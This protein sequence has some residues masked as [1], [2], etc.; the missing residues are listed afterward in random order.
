MGNDDVKILI[1]DDE[2]RN[3]DALEVMLHSTGCTLIRAHSADEALLAMLRH[4][5]AAM[6]LDIKMPGMSGIELANLV[7]QRRRTQDVPILF[8]TAHLMEDEDVLRGYG[9][10][11]VDYLS[12][13]I[14]ADI[15]RSKVAVFVDLYRKTRALA[16]LNEQLQAE[17]SERQRV[18]EAIQQIN[19]EL[20]LRVAERTAALSVAHRGVKENEERLRMA[21]DVAEIAAWEWDVKS[22]K[23][24]WSTDPEALFGFP[25]GCFGENLRIFTTLHADDKE[26]VEAAIDRAM[27]TGSTYECEYRAVRPD[28]VIVWIT[29][30]GRVLHGE[31]GVVE[32][33]VGVSRDVSAQRRAEHERE[34]LLISERAARDEAER[35]SRLKDEFLATLSHELR[36]PMNA[37]LGW[38][39]MLAKGEGVRN[40]EQAM[41]AIQRNASVQAKLIEDLLEMNKL[42]SGTVRLEL[43]L[44]DLGTAVHGALQ[45]LKP[46]ADTKG[47]ALTVTVDPAVPL[48]HA[49]E[50]RVQQI[51]WNLLHN[52]VKFTPGS[53]RV[54][55]SVT[56]NGT[57]AEVRVRDTGQGIP[58]EFLPF[59]FDRF[60]QADPSTTR[61]VWGLGIGLSIAKHLTELHGGSIEAASE[62]LDR[63]A[64]FVVHLP[65]STPAAEMHHDGAQAGVAL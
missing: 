50:R 31:D 25:A 17:I 7:K 42:M 59:V 15:L 14:K 26:G 20:E 4:E 13:P 16:V 43:A 65:I 3:L 2:I 21:M 57:S 52:A 53:G 8:L 36:T 19:Q 44:T 62:G 41:A 29:E 9:V 30:R 48:I 34:R 33:L 37:I 35:Q 27:S 38:L 32:K 23:M 64:T 63:G 45:T 60:R 10:G 12:K 54:D 55:V 11:A 1:V 61:G 56:R 18:Q 58:T 51:L 22:G 47:V 40:P 39:S 46:A 49:D 6:I 28:G 5:F 24:T